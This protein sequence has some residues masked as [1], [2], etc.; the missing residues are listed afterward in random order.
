VRVEGANVRS[1]PRAE[2]QLDR[3]RFELLP[4][5]TTRGNPQETGAARA[6]CASPAYSLSGTRPRGWG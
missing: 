6:I 1:P 4:S 5:P 3:A 2:E